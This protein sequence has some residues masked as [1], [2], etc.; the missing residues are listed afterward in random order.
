MTTLVV[1]KWYQKRDVNWTI[2]H[3]CDKCNDKRIAYIYQLMSLEFMLTQLEGSCHWLYF[4][5]I[6]L[7]D[8]VVLAH[9]CVYL[10][11]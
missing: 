8:E 6:Q 10:C 7:M 4:T 9:L 11:P 3:K 1:G 5:D 2:K